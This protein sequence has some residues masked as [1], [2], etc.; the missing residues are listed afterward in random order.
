MATATNSH[1]G[2]LCRLRYFGDE[3][4]WAFAFFAYSS[5]NYEVSMLPS[6]DFYGSPEDAS[7]TAGGLYLG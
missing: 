3:E 1:L 2:S 6:G 5:K 4:R 7:V